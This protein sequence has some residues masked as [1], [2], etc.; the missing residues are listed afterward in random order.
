MLICACECLYVS[1]CMFVRTCARAELE[2]GGFTSPNANHCRDKCASLWPTD[3]RYFLVTANSLGRLRITF[4]NGFAKRPFLPS[5]HFKEVL[6]NK[7]QQCELI[8]NHC[9]SI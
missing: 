4:A 7:E 3:L 1:V 2:I 6:Y 5:S 9:K 8:A